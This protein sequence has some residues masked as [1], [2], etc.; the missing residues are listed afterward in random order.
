VEREVKQPVHIIILGA[1]PTG[2]GAAYRLR[3]LGHNNFTLYEREERVGGLAASVYDETGFTWDFGVHV[4]FSRSAYFNCVMDTVLSGEWIEQRRDA[5]IWMH[6]QFVPYPLQYNIH[7]MPNELR[8]ECL[9]GLAR[10]A[11]RLA[12][13]P[14]NFLA[15]IVNSFGDGIARHFMVPYNEKAWAAPLDSLDVNWIAERVPRPDLKRVLANFLNS[16]DDDGWGPNAR[17]R[18]PRVGGIGAVWRR[19]AEQVGLQRIALR[20]PVTRIDPAKRYVYFADGSDERYDALISTIPLDRLV[21]IAAIDSLQP[22]TTA[23]K[24]SAVHIIGIGI[25]GGT[26]ARL[27]DRRWIYFPDPSLPF[28]RASV[29]SNFSPANAPVGHWS[30]LAEV[31]E[32]HSRLVDRTRLVDDV[33]AGMRREGIIPPSSRVVSHWQHVVAPGYPT[34]TRDRD[35]ALS[36]LLPA[37][38]GMG[39][40]SRGRFGAWKYE[41]SNQDHSFL[42]GVELAER[43]ILGR[44]ETTLATI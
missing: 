28:Y 35:R 4:L 14:T 36:L 15:W 20:R 10:A 38:E 29:L 31:S 33:V 6:G 44:A 21:M 16:R 2:L 39:I 41:I 34:P 12:D 42:Q 43:L 37:F 8:S 19:V 24:S 5:Q 26:P 1:G 7:R 3:E 25:E 17:F 30:L 27:V 13:P 11:T 32:S 18:Y 9:L 22:A 40:F 23:L